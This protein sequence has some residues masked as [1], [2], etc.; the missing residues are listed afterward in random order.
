MRVITRL[1]GIKKVTKKLATGKVKTY[2]FHRATMTR[3]PDDPT[4]LAFVEAFKACEQAPK[5]TTRGTTLS[6]LCDRYQDGFDFKQIKPSTRVEYVRYIGIIKHKFGTMPMKLL[7]T[8]QARAE[9]LEW[10]DV[11]A[12][13]SP[14]GAD[15]QMLVFG[16]VLSWGEQYAHINTNVLTKIGKKYKANRQNKFWSLDD[17]ANFSRL[18]PADLRMALTLALWTGARQGDI[19]AMPWSAYDGTRLRYTQQKTGKRMNVPVGAPLKALLDATPRRA[20]QMV[21]NTRSQPYLGPSFRAYWRKWVRAAG[22][23]GLT[24]HD[25]RGTAVTRLGIVGCSVPQIADF[26]GHDLASVTKMLQDHYLGS[27]PEMANTAVQGLE[28]FYRTHRDQSLETKMETKS[29]VAI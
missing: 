2:Y 10:R 27:D 4:K 20:I 1:K 17:E 29:Q 3:L 14:S 7:E 21:L 5:T 19:L 16:V 26:T 24:F 12:T 11:L 13:K 8:R 15:K 9:F 28:T 18:A 6:D 22:V 25:L 23:D